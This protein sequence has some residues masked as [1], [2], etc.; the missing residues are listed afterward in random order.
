MQQ[1]RNGA[2]A[3]SKADQGKRHQ[4]TL[5]SSPPAPASSPKQLVAELA[6]ARHHLERRAEANLIISEWR[7]ELR[8]RI[9]RADLEAEFIGL[10]ADEHQALHDEV[11]RYKRVCRALGW[12]PAGRR[13]P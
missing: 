6:R 8:R 2:V 3:E 4:R 7:D 1:P 10:D 5:D 9:Q 12:S 11:Q 13:R